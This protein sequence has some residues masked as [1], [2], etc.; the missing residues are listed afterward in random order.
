MRGLVNGFE[1]HERL[2]EIAGPQGAI[3]FLIVKRVG[4]AVAARRIEQRGGAVVIEEINE[5]LRV[6]G[7]RAEMVQAQFRG[8]RIAIDVEGVVFLDRVKRLH[9]TAEGNVEG[10]RNVPVGPQMAVPGGRRPA[11]GRAD[12]AGRVDVVHGFPRIGVEANHVRLRAGDEVNEV[13]IAHLA[14]PV[15]GRE[16][17]VG[18]VAADGIEPIHGARA[19]GVIVEVP[20]IGQL[21]VHELAQVGGLAAERGHVR[22]RWSPIAPRESREPRRVATWHYTSAAHPTAR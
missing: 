22:S 20:L 5:H 16:N 1:P 8:R 9:I 11:D 17:G 10:A 14:A 6:E 2:A 3:R 7:Q 21:Q 18:P 15:V 4:I 19:D 13:A 12:M